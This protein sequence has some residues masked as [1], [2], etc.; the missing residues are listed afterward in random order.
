MTR[1]IVAAALAVFFRASLSAEPF[2]WRKTL[3]QPLSP[4]NVAALVEHGHEAEVQ[5][6]WRGALSD[7]APSV[8]ASAARAIYAARADAL[9]ADVIK[10]LSTE[11]EARAAEELLRTAFLLGAAPETDVVLAVLERTRPGADTLAEMLA[12]TMGIQAL[13]PVPQLAKLDPNEQLRGG[14]LVAAVHRYGGVPL[15]RI[16][17]VVLRH[18]D[19]R[20]WAAVWDIARSGYHLDDG[21]IAGSLM[22]PNARLRAIT[23]WNLASDPDKARVLAP[24]VAGRW[25]RRH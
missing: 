10:A 23:F 4:G 21:V 25:T 19:H 11:T 24:I 20:E 7:G 9:G 8:R 16:G 12:R 22:S 18:D 15:S 14:V 6:R 17:S 3:D 13:E 2:D 5:Q 1:A